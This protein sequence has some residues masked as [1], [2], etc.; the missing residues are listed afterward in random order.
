[1]GDEDEDKADQGYDAILNSDGDVGRVNMRI[2]FQLGLS[3]ALDVLSDFSFFSRDPCDARA[4]GFDRQRQQTGTEP[5]LQPGRDA[6]TI[7]RFSTFQD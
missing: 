6:L 4:G 2:A 3:V 1:M 5:R 7:V